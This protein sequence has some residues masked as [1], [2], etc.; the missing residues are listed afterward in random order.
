MSDEE[1]RKMAIVT[2]DTEDFI[3][4]AERSRKGG[5]DHVIFS[6]SI[7]HPDRTIAAFGRDVLPHFA[8]S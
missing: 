1:I 6:D 2:E 4:I 3:R 8:K 5:M 7:A